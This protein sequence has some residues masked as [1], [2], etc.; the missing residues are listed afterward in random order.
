MLDGLRKWWGRNLWPLFAAFTLATFAV[1]VRSTQAELLAE[2]WYWLNWPTLTFTNAAPPD[3]TN[4]RVIEL[5]G[6]L[7][8]LEE[9]NRRLREMLAL[10]AGSLGKPLAAQVIGRDGDHWWRQVILNRGWADGVSKGN[11]VVAP[12]GLVGEVVATSAHTA[13][14]LLVTDPLSKIGVTATRTGAMGVISGLWRSEASLEFFDNQ[15]QAKVGDVI[16]TSG[17]SSRFPANIVVGKVTALPDKR[18]QPLQATVHFSAALD[19]L[20]WVY[21][22]PGVANRGLTGGTASDHAQSTP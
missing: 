9:E 10:P 11:P 7:S 12:G 6:R 1:W 3:F 19:G 4:S 15:A 5:E 16:V 13:R 18:V 20:N 22:Y 14:V 17:L 8:G 2:V 21:I